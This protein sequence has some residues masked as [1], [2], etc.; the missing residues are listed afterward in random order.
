MILLSVGRLVEKKGYDDLLKAL[1]ALTP[2]LAWKLIHI[3]GGELAETLKAQAEMLGIADKIILRKAQPQTVVLEAYR[4]ADLFVLPSKIA[5]DGDRD[6]I[7]NVLM[8]AQSQRLAC[9]STAVSAIPEL[10]H[11]GVSGVLVPPPRS[12]TSRALRSSGSS[13]TR[14]TADSLVIAA[15]AARSLFRHDAGIKAIAE[16]LRAAEWG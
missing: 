3:G 14:P 5:G 15:G 10:I 1:A 16:R 11:D 9:S 13:A 2:N 6:G 4:D 8:E 7:P 12:W